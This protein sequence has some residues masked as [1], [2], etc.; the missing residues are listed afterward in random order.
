MEATDHIA[1]YL[2]QHFIFSQFLKDF[3][4]YTG[5]KKRVIS[6]FKSCEFHSVAKDRPIMDLHLQPAGFSR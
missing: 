1:Y 2:W 3:Q 5:S 6:Y 4:D